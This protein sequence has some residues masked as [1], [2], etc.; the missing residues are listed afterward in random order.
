MVRRGLSWDELG[1]MAAARQFPVAEDA[2]PAD[3]VEFVRRIGPIQSQTARSPYLGLAARLPGV[4]HEEITAAYEGFGIVRGSTL[5][6]TV[7]TCAADQHVLL[8][9]ATRTG[10]RALWT[11]ALRLRRKSLEEVWSGIEEFARDEWRTPDQLTSHLVAW[12]DEH[13]G[14]DDD[15]RPVL[16]RYLGFGHGGLVRRPLRGGWEGQ[17]APG[18]RTAGAVIPGDRVGELA[19]PLVLDRLV[20]VHLAAHGPAS[21]H[22]L[23]WWSG[24]GLKVI[25]E[26]LTRL[27]LQG[28]TG[29]DGAEYVDVPD[30][31]PPT[32]L[33]GVRLLPEFDA[34]M[35]AY[36]PAGR[37]RFATSEHHDV[38]WNRKNG[39]VLPPLLVD[40]RIT[41]H[42]RSAGSA[43]R[44]PLEVSWFAGTRRPRKAEL[45]QPVAALEAALGITV[46]SVTVNRDAG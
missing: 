33:S 37:M 11:R 27:A 30:P 12:L 6:G 21:R 14:A 44:R 32:E 35:C 1:A 4:T 42:W 40:G 2:H 8:E 39:L 24:L 18:Y 43:P 9:A 22:D 28:V 26:V 16:G 38:L 17:G 20:L 45:E 41:G 34:L 19:D 31:P 10:Q 13:Q 46:T 15:V 7:H 5:R 36:Q 25:D 3:V 29:P 23:A